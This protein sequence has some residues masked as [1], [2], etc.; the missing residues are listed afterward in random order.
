MYHKV[1]KLACLILMIC[2]LAAFIIMRDITYPLGVLLGGILSIGSFYWIVAMTNQIVSTSKAKGLAVVHYLIRYLI[3]A[4]VLTIAI[5]QG[6]NI[7]SILI[8]FLCV[9]FAIRINT[10]LEG[11]EA[12]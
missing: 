1:V 5:L 12:D 7:I 3:Y 10:Y 8:G 9:S 2:A 6:L 4:V 11:K